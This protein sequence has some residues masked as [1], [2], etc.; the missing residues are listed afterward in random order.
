M[1]ANA[2]AA[3]RD[4]LIAADGFN[5]LVFL[6]ACISLLN[7]RVQNGF[8]YLFDFNLFTVRY[9]FNESN[10]G[11]KRVAFVT[12]PRMVIYK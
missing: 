1:H 8:W 2:N 10:W 12:I 4:R 9:Y 5:Y 3:M 11:R 7:H 6:N